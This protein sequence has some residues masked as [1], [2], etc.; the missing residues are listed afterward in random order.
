MEARREQALVGLFVLVAAALLIVTVFTISGVF[1]RVATTYRSYFKFAGGL[2]PG[3]EVRYVGGPKIGRVT[4]VRIDSQDPSLIEIS[5]SAKSD[6][7]VKTDSTVRIMSLSPLGE[8]HLE[9]TAGSAQA[10]R[11]RSGAALKSEPY[12]DFNAITAQL[13][14]LAPEVKQLVQTLRDRAAELKET[15]GRV[16]DL[17]NEQ[18]RVN[19][20]ASLSH[21]RGMLEENRPRIRATMGHVETASARIAPLI[22]DFKKTAKK[23]DDAVAHIDA[24]IGENRPDV[25]RAVADLRQT[26]ASAASLT[27]QLDRTLNVNSENIDE[28]LDNFRHTTENLKEFTETIKARPVTLIRGSS[29]PPRKP[30]GG[31]SKRP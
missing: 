20:A 5:F 17:M 11:A 19:V 14:T 6:V 1:G 3:A 18:N 15:V 8:N 28:L 9:V 26:L 30:G 2:E 13:N 29:P 12:V 10:P 31:A 24:M 25:R 16:N 22:D 23:A 7:P 4:K 21:I 27:E